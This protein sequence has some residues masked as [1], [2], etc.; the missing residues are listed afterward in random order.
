MAKPKL[1][2]NDSESKQLLFEFAE[3][4]TKKDKL[5]T[6]TALQVDRL[7][8]TYRNITDKEI[9]EFI[10]KLTPDLQALYRNVYYKFKKDGYK[11]YHSGVKAYRINDLSPDYRKEVQNAVDN[12]IGLIKTQNAEFIQVVQNRIRNWSTIPTPETR[13]QVPG[14]KEDIIQSLS[15]YLKATPKRYDTKEHRDFILRDQSKKLISAMNNITAKKGGAIGFIWHNRR[16]KKVVGNPAGLWPNPTRLHGDHWDREKKFYILSNS[17]AFKR[18][19]IKKT[20]NVILDIDLKDGIAGVAPGCRCWTEYIY[21][22][23]D[24]P[25]KDKSCITKKGYEYI[26]REG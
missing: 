25:V 4:L 22:I 15:K 6:A 11:R 5:N 23:E 2:I 14:S 7:L 20:K 17:W 8:S 26:S 9:K 13:G 3:S 16:D 10:R 19:L 12:S 18:G 1:N 21:N 24:I